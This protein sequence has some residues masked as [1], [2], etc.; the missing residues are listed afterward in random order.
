MNRKK[1]AARIRTLR[2]MRSREEVALACKVTAQAISMYE[3]GARIPSDDIK[4]KLAD[5]FGCSVQ[6]I[7]YDADSPADTRSA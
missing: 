7:F 4:I 3:T 6:E 2:G 1:I 5:Y